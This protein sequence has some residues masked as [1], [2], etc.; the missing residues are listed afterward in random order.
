VNEHYTFFPPRVAGLA[1]QII[2]ILILLGLS[3]WGLWQASE[4]NVGLV[5]LL[6]LLPALISTVLVP[7]LAYRVYAL[8]SARYVMKRDGVHL[9]W[10]WR[11]EDIPMNTIDW[12]TPSKKLGLRLALPWLRWPGAVLGV[13]TLQDGKRV[14]FLAS[15]TRRL[16]LIG[17]ADHIFAIS[18]EDPEAFL[19]AFQ[20]FMEM[21]SL[22]PLPARS[23]YPGFLLARVWETRAARYLLLGGLLLNLATLILVI[24][25]APSGGEITLGFG[26]GREPVPGV[27]LLLLPVISSFFFLVDVFLGFFLFRRTG[28]QTTPTFFTGTLWMI[29]GQTL[30]YLLWSSGTLVA[31]IFILQAG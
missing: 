6:Y 15:N 17:V 1:F 25:A 27:R 16:V 31:V 26:A 20:R 11:M 3:I 10:G 7:V 8:R 19:Q 21:G 24:L 22:S 28:S 12:V 5:F 30:A 13:R 29:P 9:T 2:A 18:P 4:A 23:V 14:E